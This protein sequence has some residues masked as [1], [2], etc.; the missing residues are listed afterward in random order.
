MIIIR[1][2]ER[3][4]TERL[5]LRLP[6]LADAEAIFQTFAR[7]PDVTRYTSWRPHTSIA[8]TLE[9]LAGCEQ[10]WQGERRFPYCITLKGSE[11]GIGLFEIR[12]EGFKAEVGYGIGK[13]YWGKG[14]TTE[15]ARKVVDWALAQPLIYRVWA[16]CDVD[17][18][19]SS[20]VMEKAGMQREGILRRGI[21]HPNVSSEPRDCYIYAVVK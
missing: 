11:G 6:T 16:V 18:I 3:F 5:V 12:P 20:R 2:P 21:L 13:A 1:P 17:N 4:E 10:A 8:Q 19:A 7:D 9:F 14:Y 15:A